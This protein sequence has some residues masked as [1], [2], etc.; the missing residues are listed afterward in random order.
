MLTVNFSMC[1]SDTTFLTTSI[2]H[3][4]PAIIPIHTDSADQLVNELD[5]TR[6][7]VGKLKLNSTS[8]FVDRLVVQVVQ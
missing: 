4:A 8:I 5:P 2:G 1:I 3:G 7:K 6:L